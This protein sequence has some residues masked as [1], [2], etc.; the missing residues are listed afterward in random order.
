MANPPKKK[1]FYQ[2]DEVC[3]RLGLSLLDMSVLV[4]ERKIQLCT[5]VA[6]LLVEDG[7]YEIAL[8][9]DATPIPDDRSLVQGLVNL[10]PDDAW[11]VLRHGS[12]TI[13]WLA[14]EP[15]CYRRLVST[16][17]EDRGYTVIRDEVGVRHEEFA[18]YAAIEEALDDV[19]L[20][21]KGGGRGSQPIYDW[22]AARLEAC[23]LIYFEGV[24]DSFGALIRHVQGWFAEKG[25]RVPDESTMK[26]RLRDVWAMFGSEAKT[27]AA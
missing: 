21:T 18:R 4:S 1:V 10:K 6:G 9:G 24:P 26:R 12:Q 15:D 16:S 3:E 5:A 8:D 13:F 11:F 7:H 20:G 14:A 23:R 2:I 17:E 27:K 22:D 25:G 19:A